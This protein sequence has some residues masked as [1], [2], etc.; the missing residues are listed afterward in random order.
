[1]NLQQR[2]QALLELVQAHSA[3]RCEQILAPARAEASAIRRAAL[4]GARQRVRTAIAEARQRLHAEVV[5]AE[6]RLATELRLQSQARAKA[7]LAL[8]W[9]ALERQCIA[10]WSDPA[11]RQRWLDTHL[12]R[13]FATLPTDGPWDVTLPAG[14]DDG[15]LAAVEQRLRA[16][17]MAAAR[18]RLDPQVRAG[19]RVRAGSNSLDAT[20]AGLLADRTAIEGRLLQLLQQVR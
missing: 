16:R 14:T 6:A 2:T 18:V 4:A 9:Q 19:L 10:R 17:G 7:Q 3:A 1:M 11:A 15:T 8:A 13:A 5:A 12:A 20:V